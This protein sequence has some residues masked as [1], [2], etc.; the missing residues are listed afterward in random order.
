MQ[1]YFA[2]SAF[3]LKC[4]SHNTLCTIRN[5]LGNIHNEWTLNIE[6]KKIH[7]VMSS[8]YMYF[9]LQNLTK[10]DMTTTSMKTNW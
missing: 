9:L 6:H 5:M 10:K 4:P 8:W 2:K 3:F 7:K 1:L